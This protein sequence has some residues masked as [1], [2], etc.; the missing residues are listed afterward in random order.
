[1]PLTRRE[2]E[3]LEYLGYGMTSNEM[4]ATLGLSAH[5]VDWYMNGIQDKLQAKNR[6]HVVAI[7]FRLGL[8]S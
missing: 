4:G 3:T 7:A 6:H 8:I 1:M 2:M 5:T